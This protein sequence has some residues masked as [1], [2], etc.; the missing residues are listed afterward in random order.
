MFDCVFDEYPET[1]NPLGPTSFII[2]SGDFEHALYKI[3]ESDIAGMSD[4]ELRATNNLRVTSDVPDVG[5]ERYNTSITERALKRRKLNQ[6]LRL[7]YK[8]LRF[9]LPT[10]NLHER[11][12]SVAG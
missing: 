2:S 5:N 1:A 4:S 8:D 10:S 6:S 9:I 3:L 12:I 11:F 7:R